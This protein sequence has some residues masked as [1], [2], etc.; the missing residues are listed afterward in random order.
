MKIPREF[1]LFGNKVTIR[2]IE[3]DVENRY[4]YWDDVREE[5]VVAHKVK[6]DGE[7][8]TLKQSQ[9]E[10]T[11]FHELFHAFQWYS[12]GVYDETEAQTYSMLLMEFIKSS[13]IKIDPNIVHEPIKND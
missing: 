12:R 1:T 3:K 10:S 7:F 13:E 6:V 11:V 9:I 5:I 8:I 4:G 2:E